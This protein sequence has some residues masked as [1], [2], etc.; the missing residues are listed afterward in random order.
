MSETLIR[1]AAA[2][3]IWTLLAV[4]LLIYTIKTSDAREERLMKHLDK[5]NESH[6]QIAESMQKI[7]ERMDQGFNDV[8]SRIDNLRKE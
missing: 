3:G 1:E 8:W 6:Q 5:T 4:A 2:N 7:E